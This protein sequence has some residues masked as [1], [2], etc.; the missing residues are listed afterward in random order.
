M[1]SLVRLNDKGNTVCLPCCLPWRLHYGKE[2]KTVCP[3]RT[4]WSCCME[5]RNN[6]P[7]KNAG[8]RELRPSTAWGRGRRK[9]ADEADLSHPLLFLF[10]FQVNG[11][12]GSQ[13]PPLGSLHRWNLQNHL[14]GCNTGMLAG[15]KLWSGFLLTW[16][17][18]YRETRK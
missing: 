4:R 8:K 12:K 13:P 16:L 15:Q 9:G 6:T 2:T 14:K 7:C 11:A 5:V 17:L 18:S 3:R 10:C 1:K